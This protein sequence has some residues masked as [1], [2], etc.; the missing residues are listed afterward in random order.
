MFDAFLAQ[1]WPLALVMAGIGYW[2]HVTNRQRHR[3]QVDKNTA[4]AK[5]HDMAR[6]LA[7]SAGYC[8]RAVYGAALDKALRR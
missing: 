3:A 2:A 7:F 8:Q 5:A 6:T 1:V 4:N